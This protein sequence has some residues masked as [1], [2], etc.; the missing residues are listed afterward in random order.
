MFFQNTGGDCCPDWVVECQNF[1]CNGALY[2]A[3]VTRLFT[4]AREPGCQ[5]GGWWC[6]PTRGSRLHT[7]DTSNISEAIPLSEEYANEA[8]A[9]LVSSGVVTD[10]SVTAEYAGNQSVSI[11][12]SITQPSGCQETFGFSSGQYGWVWNG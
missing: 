5:G 9:D 12:V 2:D 6:D 3:I 1:S 8:L 7:V 11:T 10:L 4:E